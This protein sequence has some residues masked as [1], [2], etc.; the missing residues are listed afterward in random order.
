MNPRSG[1]GGGGGDLWRSATTRGRVSAGGRGHASSPGGGGSG[2]TFLA[3]SRGTF[4]GGE[5]WATWAAGRDDAFSARLFPTPET[6]EVQPK[7]SD[8]RAYAAIVAT[9]ASDLPEQK[10]NGLAFPG[11]LIGGRAGD[12][13]ANRHPGADEA[14]PPPARSSRWRV[15][16]EHGRRN[17]MWPQKVRTECA[18]RVGPGARVDSGSRRGNQE[19]GAPQFGGE[20]KKKQRK[21]K[22]RKSGDG[23]GQEGRGRFSST[24]GRKKKS[25]REETNDRKVG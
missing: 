1:P 7:H 12:A 6:R 18:I 9:A 19:G 23:G 4:A 24:G 8:A 20:I 13:G 16:T 17:A 14:G 25:K 3:L 2:S 5:R 15:W 10:T 22:G 11:V 21:G